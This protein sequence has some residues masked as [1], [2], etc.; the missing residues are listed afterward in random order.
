MNGKGDKARPFAVS[1][2]TYEDRY[3]AIFGKKEDEM[4]DEMEEIKNEYTP[5]YAVSPGEVLAYQIRSSGVLLEGGT[6]LYA[7][8][9]IDEIY[10]IING[11]K[12]ITPEIAFN[13]GNCGQGAEYWLQLEKNYQDQLTES[14]PVQILI[15]KETTLFK[16]WLKECPI[17][18]K[19]THNYGSHLCY[20]F[21]V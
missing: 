14:H 3:D 9:P 7:G 21:W 4:E 15:Q 13:L 2:E 18:Y 16:K 20:E 12:Q 10:E 8:I 1:R 19:E 11:N 5:D 6:A 17:D